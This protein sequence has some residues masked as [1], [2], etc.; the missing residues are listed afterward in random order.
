MS[1][2]IYCVYTEMWELNNPFNIMGDKVAMVTFGAKFLDTINM[3]KAHDCKQNLL[4]TI[5]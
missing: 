3:S 4:P 5:L 1:F 2:E